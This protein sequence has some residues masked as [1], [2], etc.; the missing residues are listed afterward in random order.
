MKE[1]VQHGL[2]LGTAR[3]P[4]R[5]LV[6]TSA[7]PEIVWLCSLLVAGVLFNSDVEMP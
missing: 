5:M 7:I 1:P 4:A 6:R 3:Q 2:V